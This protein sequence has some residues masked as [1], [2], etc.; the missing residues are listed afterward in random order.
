[1]DLSPCTRFFRRTFRGGVIPLVLAATVLTGACGSVGSSGAADRDGPADLAFADGT[2]TTASTL[3]AA[4][5]DVALS[6]RDAEFVRFES[7]WVCEVQRRTFATEDGR[8]LALIEKLA[9]FG[10]DEAEYRAFRAR[11]NDEQDLRDSILF[12]YQETCRP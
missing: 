11:V 12:S 9:E 5:P 3:I 1:M 2:P 10:L 8:E 7:T 4:A 6:Q